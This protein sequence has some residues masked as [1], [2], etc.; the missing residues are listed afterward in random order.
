MVLTIA[1][2][3]ACMYL[4][5]LNLNAKHDPGAHYTTCCRHKMPELGMI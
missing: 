1:V 3:T 2:Q 4:F 5:V